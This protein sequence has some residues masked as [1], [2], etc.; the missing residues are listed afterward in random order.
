MPR[1]AAGAA[2]APPLPWNQILALTLM[3]CMTDTPSCPH[4]YRLLNTTATISQPR[5]GI[6]ERSAFNP[7]HDNPQASLLL[8][9]PRQQAALITAGHATTDGA[10]GTRCCWSCSVLCMALY[11]WHLCAAEPTCCWHHMPLARAR[12]CWQQALREAP[13]PATVLHRPWHSRRCTLAPGRL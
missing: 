11:C 2:L 10:S 9:Q 12:C 6:T 8:Q 7:Q 4:H 1:A 3:S 5:P 13:A